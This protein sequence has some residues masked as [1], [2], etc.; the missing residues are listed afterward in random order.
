MTENSNANRSAFIKLAGFI[1]KSIDRLSNLAGTFAGVMLLGCAAVAFWEVIARRIVNRPTHWEPDI[2]VYLLIWIGFLAAGYGLKEDSH[3]IVDSVVDKLKPRVG[4][5]LKTLSYLLVAAYASVFTLYA[6]RMTWQSFNMH[7]VAFTQWR[8]VIWPV[9]LGVPVGMAILALQALKMCAQSGQKFHELRNREEE[10]SLTRCVL[11]VC[12][13]LALVVFSI[14]LF[15]VTPIIGS[16]LLL[17][18]VLAAGVPVGFTLGIVGCTGLLLCF[19]T[20]QALINMPVL[21]FFSNE[22]LHHCCASSFPYR[23]F[24]YEGR[25]PCRRAS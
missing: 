4:A 10:G 11:T 20:D 16:I 2:V 8:V 22:Q 15:D 7:E 23:R 3:V 21:G 6:V 17:S 13:F 14:W 24:N 25:R 5:A 12:V 9:K 1:G 19:G 18:C